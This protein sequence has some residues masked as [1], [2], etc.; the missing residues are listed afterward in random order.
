MSCDVLC[1]CGVQGTR[2]RAREAGTGTRSVRGPASFGAH[3]QQ[4]AQ[5]GVGGCMEN[6]WGHRWQTGRMENVR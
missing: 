1:M 3:G 4:A 6:V 5:R 2:G